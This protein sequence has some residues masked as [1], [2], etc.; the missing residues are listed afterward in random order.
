MVGIAGEVVI[1]VVGAVYLVVTGFAF[2]S[3]ERPAKDELYDR[4][5]EGE[6]KNE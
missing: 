4:D 1:A 2:R 3:R 5:E 6:W